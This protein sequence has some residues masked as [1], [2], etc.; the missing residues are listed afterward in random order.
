MKI[1]S[2]IRKISTRGRFSEAR[3]K[4]RRGMKRDALDALF[5]K[6]IRSRDKW[7]CQRCWKQYPPPTQALHCAHIFSRGKLSTRYDCDG[8]AALCYGC[9]RWLDTHPLV[10]E[11][12][13]R[14]WLGEERYNALAVRA[15]T[16]AKI[17]PEAIK[18]LLKEKL[19]AMTE[20]LAA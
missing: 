13:F 2:P 18:L 17:D 19:T 3:C 20:E 5:S 10:K 12:F 9:H 1:R 8:A 15:A 14:E 6:F 16:P 7:T 4:K 11:A